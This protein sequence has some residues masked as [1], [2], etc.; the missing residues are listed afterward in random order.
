MHILQYVFYK[1]IY[2]ISFISKFINSIFS[3]F[4]NYNT[5]LKS[6]DN[7]F[8]YLNVINIFGKFRVDCRWIR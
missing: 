4:P 6:E 2:K 1:K 5:F 8:I 7:K 3:I